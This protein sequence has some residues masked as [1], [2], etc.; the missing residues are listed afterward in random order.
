MSPD[1]QR[2]IAHDIEHV[3]VRFFNSLDACDYDRLVEQFAGDGAWH[4][5]GKVLRGAAELMAAMRARPAGVT[6]HVAS[7]ILIDIAGA[8]Q[9]TVSAYLVIFAHLGGSETPAPMEL[10]LSAAIYNARMVRTAAGWRI[11]ELTSQIRFKR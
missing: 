11:A 2:A 9:A 6:Q 3:I 1:E 10:P 7:N 8:D 4:R 5:Q